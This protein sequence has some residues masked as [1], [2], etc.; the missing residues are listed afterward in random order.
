[1]NIKVTI[2][3]YNY[4]IDKIYKPL[5]LEDFTQIIL[6]IKLIPK[7]PNKTYT[8]SKKSKFLIQLNINFN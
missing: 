5:N 1:M 8:R 4:K 6:K 7:Y 3:I 2:F